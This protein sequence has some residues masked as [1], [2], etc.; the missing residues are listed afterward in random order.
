MDSGRAVYCYQYSTIDIRDNCNVLFNNNRATT[1]GGAVYSVLHCH[2]QISENSST[3]FSFNSANCDR[4][5]ENPH[6]MH[7]YKSW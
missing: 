6:S 2:I 5:S 4:L 1:G 3:S 7:F